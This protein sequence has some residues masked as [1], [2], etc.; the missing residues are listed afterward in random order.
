MAH[1]FRHQLGKPRIKVAGLPALDACAY[2][3][4]YIR[5]CRIQAVHGCVVACTSCTY[6][7]GLYFWLYMLV[8]TR[9]P[10][11]AVCCCHLLLEAAAC[12]L[13]TCNSVESDPKPLLR[14]KA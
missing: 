11:Q 12:E 13:A 10:L 7:L 5:S 8:T 6:C 3:T 14:L 1:E 9:C 4:T 2:Q